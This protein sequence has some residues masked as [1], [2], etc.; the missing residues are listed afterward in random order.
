MT[1]EFHRVNFTLSTS[2]QNSQPE[3]SDDLTILTAIVKRFA[4]LL[5]LPGALRVARR[6][7]GMVVDDEGNVLEYDPAGPFG[8]ITQLIDEFSIVLGSSAATLAHTAMEP[9]APTADTGL[10]AESAEYGTSRAS[11]TPLRLMLVDDH[12]LFRHGLTRLLDAQPDFK[13][14]GEASTMQEAIALARE[15]QPDIVLMDISLPDGNGIQATHAI[16]AERPRTKIVFLTVH[17]DDESLFAAIRAGGIGYLP[18]SVSAAELIS[19]LRGA[20]RGEAAISAGIARRVLEEFSRLPPPNDI[21]EQ[22]EIQ[23]TF[24][25]KEILSAMASGATNHEIA[26]RLVISEHTVK[27]HVKRVLAKLHLHSRRDAA[28]YARQHGLISPRNKHLE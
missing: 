27:N 6:V 21:N 24:R 5:G 23:L 11:I 13:V 7:P 12:V 1:G 14:V 22:R 16:V 18:K 4:R 20:G 9:L 3:P 8:V 19:R 28:R 10:A 17:E 25:E 2:S 26:Q 15:R